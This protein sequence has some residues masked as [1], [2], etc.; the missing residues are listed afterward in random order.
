MVVKTPDRIERTDSKMPLFIRVQEPFLMK[1]KIEMP[2]SGLD[3]NALIYLASAD[4][5]VLKVLLNMKTLAVNLISE[6]VLSD[7]AGSVNQFEFAGQ[8]LFIG[9]S[10]QSYFLPKHDCPNY[11]SSR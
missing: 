11:C 4:G 6:V 9:T 3:K 2:S 1:L 8:K 5:H 10:R 7:F